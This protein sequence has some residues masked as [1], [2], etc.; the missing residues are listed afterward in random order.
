MWASWQHISKCDNF[1]CSLSTCSLFNIHKCSVSLNPNESLSALKTTENQCRQVLSLACR[2]GSGIG[3]Y[4]SCAPLDFLSPFCR[5]W[6]F[7][8][9]TF[10]QQLSQCRMHTCYHAGVLANAWLSSQGPCWTRSVTVWC[11]AVAGLMGPIE[12]GM[13][14]LFQLETIYADLEVGLSTLSWQWW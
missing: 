6:L 1:A 2:T 11:T 9:Y 3:L 14:R 7:K 12:Q 10:A 13:S 4:P 5:K 8:Y